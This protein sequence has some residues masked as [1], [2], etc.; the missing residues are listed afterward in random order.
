MVA[1]NVADFSGIEVAL[2]NPLTVGGR[3]AER[4]QTPQLRRKRIAKAGQQLGGWM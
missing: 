2:L 4:A 3:G 1:P